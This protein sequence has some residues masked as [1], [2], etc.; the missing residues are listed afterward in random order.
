MILDY[1]INTTTLVCEHI[2][3]VAYDEDEEKWYI[4]S[5]S[6][7]RVTNKMFQRIMETNG[8]TKLSIHSLIYKANGYKK[9]QAYDNT[10][11]LISE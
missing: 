7:E 5:G 4:Q 10:L 9:K 8:T 6:L 3:C 1:D 2:E 11:K